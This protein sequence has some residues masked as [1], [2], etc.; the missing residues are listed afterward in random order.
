MME[1]DAQHDHDTL[2]PD[3]YQE[4]IQTNYLLRFDTTETNDEE[5]EVLT[6]PTYQKSSRKSKLF[7][8][9]GVAGVLL[10]FVALVAVM[11]FNS[12]FVAQANEV[13]DEQERELIRL[14][15]AI[16]RQVQFNKD[17]EAKLAILYN[18]QNAIL[19]AQHEVEGINQMNTP[20]QN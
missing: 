6:P 10:L 4:E 18:T 1:E 12:V 20:S 11:A 15:N 5:G 16:A 17:T 19:E 8:G 14:D 9:V 7:V 3:N 13:N 2:N